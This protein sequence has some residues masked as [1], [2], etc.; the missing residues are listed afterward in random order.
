MKPETESSKFWLPIVSRPSQIYY[1]PCPS[2]PFPIYLSW[3]AEKSP[4][5][6][7]TRK[8][9]PGKK[10]ASPKKRSLLKENLPRDVEQF[11]NF[12]RLITPDDSTHIKR[13]STLTPR[14]YIHLTARNTRLETFFPEILFLRTIFEDFFSKD[15]LSR[16][17]FFREFFSQGLFIRGLFS[18]NFLPRFISILK[19]LCHTS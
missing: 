9:V 3:Y 11:I 4:R 6:K 14:S 15:L 2:S 5:K 16:E 12:Y 7:G 18:V 17:T 19:V 13:C 10:R 1:L 8:K